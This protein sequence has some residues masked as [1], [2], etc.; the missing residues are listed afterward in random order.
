MYIIGDDG[1]DIVNVDVAFA[2]GRA[3][4]PDGN[5]A[6][7]AYGPGITSI[8]I[9]GSEHRVEA[10][11]RAIHEA[12]KNGQPEILD[13]AQAVGV[14]SRPAA[15]TALTVPKIVVPTDVRPNGGR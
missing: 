6:L 2:F 5:A 14:G 8:L 12:L 10:G 15:S 4:L 13:L 3:V 11:M 1:Q 7:V 9:K